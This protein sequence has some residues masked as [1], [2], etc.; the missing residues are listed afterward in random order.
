MDIDEPLSLVEICLYLLIQGG[1][2]LFG[3]I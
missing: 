2:H 3:K 1:W